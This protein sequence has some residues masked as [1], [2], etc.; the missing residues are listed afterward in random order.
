MKPA[1]RF[2]LGVLFALPVLT[3]CTDNCQQTRTYRKTVPVQIALDDLRKPITSGPAQAV[4]DPGKLYVKDQYLFIV[5]LKKG[6]H[7]FDNSNPASP[8]AISFLTIPGTV[9]LAV[10]DNILYADSFIDL[11][12]ID[13][14]NPASVREV[15]RVA[16]GFKNGQIGRTY[17]NYDS[18]NRKLNDNREEIATETVQTDCEGSFNIL[19]YL[20]AVT[21][22]GRGYYLNDFASYAQLSNSSTA[23]PTAPTVGTGGSMA[24]FALL[25]DQLYVVN[26]YSMQLFDL[27][28][29]AT[30]KRT[31]T[32]NLGWNVETIFPYRQNLYIGT[33]TGM[34]IFDASKPAEPKQVA[35]FPHARS[36]DPVVV[37]ENYAYV[38]LRGTT[39]CGNGNQQ[40]VLDIVNIADPTRPQLVKSYPLET[41]YGLGVDFPTL[42]VCRGTKGLSVFDISNPTNPEPRQ[43]FPNAHAFD[44]IPLAKVLLMIG[45]DGLYQYDYS[46]PANLRLLSRIA[47]QPPV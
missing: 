25:N 1:F 27:A 17:W 26:N 8:R 18:L 44:V 47:V 34:F 5:E 37:H 19:P 41:P 43:T 13:I 16:T 11:V 35:A 12:S 38:T 10:R 24:R 31:K 36:C 46:D 22:F 45:K 39:T 6:I 2:L 42:F 29:P 30:P 33:T 14:S 20:Y 40:D 3:G 21:W 28:Q 7:V 9:D 32:I 15:G 23:S 4:A